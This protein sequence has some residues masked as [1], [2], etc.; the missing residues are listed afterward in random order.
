MGFVLLNIHV[1]YLNTGHAR[2]DQ[3]EQAY[4]EASTL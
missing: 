4:Y 2:V 1:H 3:G